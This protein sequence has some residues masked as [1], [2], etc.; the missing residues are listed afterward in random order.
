MAH[1]FD[2]QKAETKGYLAEIQEKTDLPETADMDY[3]FVPSSED[4]DWQALA[5]A[6]TKQGF[7]CEFVEDEDDELPYLVA[8]S[9]DQ[10]MSVAGIWISE[11]VATRI[12]LEHGFAPDG[13]GFSA[14]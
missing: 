2:A 7:A 10:A 14:D 1:D 13:W 3:F 5:D 11:E 4:A 12:A 6:L 8:T 9:T